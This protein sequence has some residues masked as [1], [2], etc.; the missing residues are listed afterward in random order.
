MELFEVSAPD[1]GKEVSSRSKAE[2]LLPRIVGR[3]EVLVE[4]LLRHHAL[5]LIE[6]PFLDQPLGALRIPD[7]VMFS[8]MHVTYG[9]LSFVS[10]ES[11][12]HFTCFFCLLY[13]IRILCVVSCFSRDS[14]CM[15]S[16]SVSIS[17]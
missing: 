12:S 5:H 7:N 9:A 13:L 17:Y 4:L 11:H 14:H 8:G 1:W 3:G 16:L 15:S 2:P 6:H 10:R